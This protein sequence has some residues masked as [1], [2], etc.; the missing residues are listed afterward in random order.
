MI[1]GLIDRNENLVI[2]KI[3]NMVIKYITKGY[4]I[5]NHGLCYS[6]KGIIERLVE[7]VNF[8]EG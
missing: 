8:Q 4:K 6:R 1:I 3:L 5:H 7:L 2:L